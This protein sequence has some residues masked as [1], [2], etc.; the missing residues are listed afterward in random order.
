MWNPTKISNG[1][2]E[3]VREVIVDCGKVEGGY[4]RKLPYRR[5]KLFR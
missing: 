1:E 5:E 2:P 3:L 4:A